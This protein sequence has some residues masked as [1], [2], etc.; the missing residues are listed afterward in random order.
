MVQDLEG[1][2]EELVRVE[3]EAVCIFQPGELV[4]ALKSPVSAIF[5][6]F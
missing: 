3:A 6:V 4:S 5:S 2:P 1:D